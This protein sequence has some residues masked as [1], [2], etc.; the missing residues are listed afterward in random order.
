MIHTEDLPRSTIV[1]SERDVEESP[2]A[3]D[4]QRTLAPMVRVA[5]RRGAGL[6]AV[7]CWVRQTLERIAGPNPQLPEA[8]APQITRLLCAAL[9]NSHRPEPCRPPALVTVAR[10]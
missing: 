8:Y 10:R 5:L 9:R 3:E 7:V 2:A 1:L 4:L 6:P